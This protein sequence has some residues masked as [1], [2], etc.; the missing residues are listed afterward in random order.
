MAEIFVAVIGA[1]HCSAEEAANAE[2]VG[3]ELAKRGA[4]VLCGG[5][6]GVMEAVCRGVVA[7]GGLTVG[8]LP[9]DNPQEANPYVKIPI[10]TGLGYARNVIIVKSAQAVIAV[11]GS[12]GT[13]SEIAFAFQNGLPVIGLNTWTIA[14]PGGKENPIIMAQEPVEAV[15]KALAAVRGKTASRRSTGGKRG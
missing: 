10:A 2:A 11:G 12:Y 5:L 14:E 9:G 15:D 3:R 8:I 7:E 6:G 4:V 13:L 1:S